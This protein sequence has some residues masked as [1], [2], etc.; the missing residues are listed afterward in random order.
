MLV[1]TKKLISQQFPEAERNEKLVANKKSV[2]TQ[3]I[4]IMTRTRL[5]HQNSIAILSKSVAT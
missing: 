1:M 2:A 3:D 5:L 4:P